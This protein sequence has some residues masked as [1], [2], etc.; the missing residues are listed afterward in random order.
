M[1]AKLRDV[2]NNPIRR[3]FL[4]RADSYQVFGL[5]CPVLLVLTACGKDSPTTPEPEPPPPVIPVATRI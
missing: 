1:K 2:R 5:I 4:L 3:F